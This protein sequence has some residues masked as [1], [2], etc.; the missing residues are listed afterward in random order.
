M[1]RW[2]PDAAGR[3][4]QAALALFGEQG[5]ERT[6][7]A[8]IAR[9]AGLTERTFFRHYADKREVLF[10]GSTALRDALVAGV[11]AAPPS[12]DPMAAVVHVLTDV[13][14]AYF[15]PRRDF[16][17]RRQAIV[18]AHAELQERELMKMTMLA[19]ALTDAL[20]RRGVTDPAATLVAEAGITVFRVAFDRWVTDDTFATLGDAVL[21]TAAALAAVAGGQ[22]RAGRR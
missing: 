1:A 5:F 20:R 13:G 3:L 21:D 10:A 17:R 16:A 9:S 4:A 18:G 12:V 11:D 8:E 6:T 7:V 14:T 15:D 19:S 2:E 22:A